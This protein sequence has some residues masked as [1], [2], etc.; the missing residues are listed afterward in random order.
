MIHDL[1]HYFWCHINNNHSNK[2]AERERQMVFI[3]AGDICYASTVT[4]YLL[5][6]L[7]QFRTIIQ[8]MLAVSSWYYV[9]KCTAKLL[10]NHRVNKIE[11]LNEVKYICHVQC[12]PC[13]YLQ[14]CAKLV[15]QLLRVSVPSLESWHWMKRSN[16]RSQRQRHGSAIYIIGVIDELWK[17]TRQNDSFLTTSDCYWES[18]IW[19]KKGRQRELYL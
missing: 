6:E 4:V 15:E 13:G 17:I 1:I 10:I 9:V 16:Q 5:W 8:S 2:D 3:S 14:T 19:C 7:F 12:I 18:L 11:F